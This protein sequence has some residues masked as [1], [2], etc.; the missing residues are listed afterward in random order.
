MGTLEEQLRN[1]IRDFMNNFEPEVVLDQI[2]DLFQMA[3]VTDEF[4]ELESTEK[5]NYVFMYKKFKELVKN[6]HKIGKEV[7]NAN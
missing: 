7:K 6:I 4:A 2:D 5:R 3:V 1:L